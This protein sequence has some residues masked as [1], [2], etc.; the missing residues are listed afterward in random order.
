M[1]SFGG[2]FV[3]CFYKPNG[4]RF[5]S[6]NRDLFDAEYDSAVHRIEQFVEEEKTSAFISIKFT[7]R[8]ENARVIT[9][10]SVPVG[11]I[12][13]AAD[14]R[15]RPQSS[16][17]CHR[18]GLMIRF[19]DVQRW[20]LDVRGASTYLIN[21][22]GSSFWDDSRLFF[23]EPLHRPQPILQLFFYFYPRPALSCC[24]STSSGRPSSPA[25]DIFYSHCSYRDGLWS[26]VSKD[27][28]TSIGP[29]DF[30]CFSFST[31]SV[32]INTNTHRW[33]HFNHTTALHIIMSI[34]SLEQY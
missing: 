23:F 10:S 8:S 34:N 29:M 12:K 22:V 17:T 21:N 27:K 4:R 18:P 9:A 2:F 25:S 3:F 14:C 13:T 16:S 5:V 1:I 33:K 24:C 6:S 26:T 28:C 11:S 31:S 7:D 19:S 30:T 20:R 32:S 15:Y